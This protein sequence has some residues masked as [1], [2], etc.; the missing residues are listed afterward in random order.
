M[1]TDRQASIVRPS[2]LDLRSVITRPLG[3]RHQ[4]PSP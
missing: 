3:A 2:E 4:G 1:F